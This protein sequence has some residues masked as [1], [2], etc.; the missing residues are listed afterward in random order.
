LVATSG[1]A[2]QADRPVAEHT[3]A[4]ADTASGPVNARPDSSKRSLTH[5]VSR[6]ISDQILVR[7]D[8]AAP[9]VV[10][11]PADMPYRAHRGRIIRSI[12]IARVGVFEYYDGTTARSTESRVGRIGDV[13][14]FD[15]RPSTLAKYFL[16]HV[17]DPLDAET[18]ADTERLLRRTT[19][20]LDAKIEVLP[21]PEAPDSVDVLVIT[22]DRWSLGIEP[23]VRTSRRY[24]FDV[25]ERNVIGLGHQL[26]F[27]FDVDLDLDR[28][29]GY[30]GT[31]RSD[32]IQGTF[33]RGEYR[34]RDT[35][36][37]RSHRALFARQHVA[38]Q[39]LYTGALELE[40]AKLL[41][42]VESDSTVT[43][44]RGDVW[45]GRAF[46]LGK[47]PLGGTSRTAITPATR[48]QRIDYDER[49]AVTESTNR[50]FR[51]RTIWLSSVSLNRSRFRESR[52]ILGYG[53]T[54]DIPYGFL[55][56]FT[57]GAEFDEFG[58]RPYADGK[59]RAATYSERFGYAFGAA[60]LG[61]HRRNGDWEDTV[62]RLD[63]AY[64]SP[65]S[66]LGGFRFRHFL[67]V[68]Y[69][70]GTMQRT[71]GKLAL[72]RSHG[73]VAIDGNDQS[74]D[75]RL[76]AGLESVTFTPLQ[77]WGFKFAL[78]EFL[79]TGVVGPDHGSLLERRYT[80]SAGFGLRFHNERLIFNP[81]ELRFAFLLSAPDGT[82]INSFRFGTSR[83]ADL[84]GLEP[85]A[86]AS[87]PF[88]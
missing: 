53:R 34:Y 82:T 80:T 28:T 42:Q 52:L 77:F 64:F 51:D 29:V 32:N 21:V 74:G 59:A 24:D 30:T 8:G 7:S 20:I 73:L 68:S 54:E 75:Q 61:A 22:R 50:G 47:S 55:V 81:L 27:N 87:V 67:D 18:L 83:S 5:R 35:H 56:T 26:A 31:Y 25:E 4:A 69:T 23:S 16:M 66:T 79:S 60:A 45:V 57:G 72:D 33:A 3:R 88:E 76:V 46:P 85:G 86:P 15:S 17:G 36:I 37:E 65:L 49:P 44:Y 71:A 84:P 38:P 2:Q 58:T 12:R 1:Q 10:A 70:R 39:I 41:R 6:L 13:L 63:A 19:F 11:E 62:L 40:Y 78:F 43:F 9:G 14:H 48:V